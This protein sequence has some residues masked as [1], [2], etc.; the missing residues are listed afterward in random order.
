MDV[1]YD[2]CHSAEAE[3]T[4]LEPIVDSWGWREFISLADLN[5]LTKGYLVN[6]TI[7]IEACLSTN[8]MIPTP[9]RCPPFLSVCNSE[10][11]LFE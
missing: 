3:T 6:D 10:V 5:A 11:S 2:A 7:M 9:N 1:S 8:S 4:L